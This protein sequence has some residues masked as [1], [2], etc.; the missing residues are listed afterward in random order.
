MQYV[1]AEH[2]YSIPALL[3]QLPALYCLTHR[4]INSNEEKGEEGRRWQGEQEEKKEVQVYV[5]ISRNR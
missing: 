3:Y 5:E 1:N 2:C 4:L